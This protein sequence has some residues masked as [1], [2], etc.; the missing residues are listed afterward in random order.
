MVVLTCS[1]ELLQV[2]NMAETETQLMSSVALIGK[3]KISYL[4][5]LKKKKKNMFDL[6]NATH[7]VMV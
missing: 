7:V 2:W 4:F 1:S 6:Q 5:P 3:C